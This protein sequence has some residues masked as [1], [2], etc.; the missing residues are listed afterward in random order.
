MQRELHASLRGAAEKS[1]MEDEKTI[2]RR[3]YAAR[4]Q[5]EGS[6]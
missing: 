3:A 6:A 1:K 5:D 4:V 2:V